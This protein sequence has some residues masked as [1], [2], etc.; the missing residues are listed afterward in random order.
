MHNNSNNNINFKPNNNPFVQQTKPLG[1]S[2]INTMQNIQQNIVVNSNPSFN[3]IEKTNSSGFKKSPLSERKNEDIG[4]KKAEGKPG[5]EINMKN[6]INAFLGITNVNKMGASGEKDKKFDFTVEGEEVVKKD[7][8]VGF[9]VNKDVEGWDFK[10][11]QLFNR[12]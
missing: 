6:L 1:V 9:N 12:E 3:T 10:R 8:N 4:F 11:Y 5:D 2:N 7:G